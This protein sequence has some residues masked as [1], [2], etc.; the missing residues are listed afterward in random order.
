MTVAVAVRSPLT[1]TNMNAELLLA[2]CEHD[3]PVVPTI[4]PMAGTTAPYSKAST[5]LLSNVE[6]VFMAALAQMIRPGQPY[7]YLFG[8][9][10]TDMRNGGDL[11][12]TLDKALWKIA[13]VQLGKAYRMPTAAEC[14]G[15]MTVRSDLQSGAEGMLFML[16]AQQSGADLL[17]GIG[18]C[19]NAMA[20]SAEMMLVQTAWLKAA[21]FLTAGLDTDVHLAVENIRRTGPGGHYMTDD[22]T[23]ELLRSDEFFDNELFDYSDLHEGQPSMLERAHQKAMEMTAGFECPHPGKVQDELRRFFRDECG[24]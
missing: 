23:L 22:L 24:G 9:S 16:G 15:S 13:G 8:P 1:L 21:R 20:M 6:A 4:C 19:G 5:L 18:S 2:A 3:L 12:Y 14:G 7:L 17:A 11:Y 10:R